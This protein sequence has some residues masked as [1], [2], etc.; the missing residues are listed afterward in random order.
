MTQASP[1]TTG[2]AKAL[3]HTASALSNLQP[4]HAMTSE[5]ILLA[6]LCDP[7]LTDTGAPILEEP[8]LRRAILESSEPR[9]HRG[10]SPGASATYD[11]AW[12]RAVARERSRPIGER[13][14]SSLGAIASGNRA[15]PLVFALHG[16]LSVGDL[17]HGLAG[18]SAL[19]DDVLRRRAL[20]PQQLDGDVAAEVSYPSGLADDAVVDVVALNDDVTPM[21]FVVEALQRH[22]GHDALRAMHCTYRI[23]ACGRARIATCGRRLAE[24]RIDA[25][26]E[27]ARRLSFPLALVYGP[28]VG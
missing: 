8:E 10:W 7:A 3:L 17:A 12:Q 14:R 19:V 22:F 9:D 13:V 26:H 4:Q 28:R 6:L 21:D 25:V 27:A 16:V 5:A 23:D 18:A 2:A 15:V 1:Q 11:R 24:E 20:D